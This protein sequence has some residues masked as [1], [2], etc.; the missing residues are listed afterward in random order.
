MVKKLNLKIPRP[1]E[2]DFRRACQLRQATLS[3]ALRRQMRL[4]VQEVRAAHPD[5][6]EWPLTP[7]QQS[8]L[9]AIEDGL[10]EFEQLVSE[11][12]LPRR[13]VQKILAELIDAGRVEA[14]PQGGKTEVAR[15]ARR[16]LFVLTEQKRQQ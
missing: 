2:R 9:E 15:G 3:E 6:D 4:F 13:Q 10:F 14:R 7:N 16:T 1:L 11:T 5:F 12:L 8:V